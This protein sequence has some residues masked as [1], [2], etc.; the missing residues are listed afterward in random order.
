MKCN[1]KSC[2]KSKNILANG[3]C[4]SC[5]EARNT[6]NTQQNHV[7]IQKKVEI[8]VKE[9]EAIYSKLKNGEVINQNVVNSIIIGGVLNFIVHQ[10]TAQK[11]EAKVMKL[12]T[13]LK[14]SKCRIESLEN[15]MNKNDEAMINLK[16]TFAKF[17]V[18]NLEVK[19]KVE[20]SKNSDVAK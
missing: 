1:T 19:K 15:W 3:F 2:Q 6:D 16:E 14:T 8:D 11:L 18:P 5:N 12:E 10:E 9:I 13:E 7:S 4:K 17:S 20:I